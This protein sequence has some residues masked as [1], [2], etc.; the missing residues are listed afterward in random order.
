MQAHSGMEAVTYQPFGISLF[1]EGLIAAGRLDEALEALAKA[2]SIS[3]RTGERFYLAELRR[4]KAEI[5]AAQGRRSEAE[6][7]LR[8]AIELSRAQGAKLFELRSATT[9]CRLLDG[10]RREAVLHDDLEPVYRWFEPGIDTP[11]LQDAR[12]LLTRTTG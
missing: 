5:L 4:L 7:A 1:V 10:S 9:L 8:E 3:E 6:H 12:A 2:L 11:D